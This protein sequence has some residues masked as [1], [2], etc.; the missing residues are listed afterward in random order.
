MRTPALG[1][2]FRSV[3]I[4]GAKI[5]VALQDAMSWRAQA[6]SECQARVILGTAETE[7]VHSFFEAARTMNLGGIAGFTAP[8]WASN[9]VAPDEGSETPQGMVTA[10]RFT[11][12]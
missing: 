4:H 12:L 7:I 11:A 9:V 10:Y 3:E 5:P 8:A 1:D 6:E 2:H